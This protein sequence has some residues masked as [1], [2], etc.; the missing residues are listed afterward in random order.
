[1]RRRA[2]AP[3][4]LPSV[5]ANMSSCADLLTVNTPRMMNDNLNLVLRAPLVS[6]L[7]PFTLTMP[8]IRKVQ[9]KS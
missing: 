8:P 5:C 1:M 9:T 2:A 7:K 6:Y 4:I 3:P